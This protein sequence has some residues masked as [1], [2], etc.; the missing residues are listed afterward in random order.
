MIRTLILSAC[1]AAPLFGLAP[2]AVSAGGVTLPM[3]PVGAPE[4]TAPSFNAYSNSFDT[5]KG[6][7]IGDEMFRFTPSPPEIVSILFSR[8]SLSDMNN[9]A[10]PTIGGAIMTGSNSNNGA[11]SVTEAPEVSTWAMTL[12]GFAGLGFMG[13]LVR[14]RR[15]ADPIAL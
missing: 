1:A 6:K 14:K 7:G 13:S 4:L 12:L 2:G 15:G 3:S 9:N 8:S 10:D 11:V 5:T